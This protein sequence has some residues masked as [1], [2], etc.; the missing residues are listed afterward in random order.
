MTRT[1]FIL[2]A[3][4]L[5]APAALAAD[6]PSPQGAGNNANSVLSSKPAAAAP[7]TSNPNAPDTGGYHSSAPSPEGAGN[8][9]NTVLSTPA[10]AAPAPASAPSTMNAPDTYHAA[11]P[12][13][14]AAYKSTTDCLNAA[15]A[16]HAPL[17]QCEQGRSK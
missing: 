4:L 14:P 9:A 3:G 8:N 6:A 15:Q 17:G 11:A 7:A 1:V 2:A 13:N 16:A 12:F 5:I 10:P